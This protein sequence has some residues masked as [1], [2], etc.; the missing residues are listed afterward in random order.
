MVHKAISIFA[1]LL[2]LHCLQTNS[3]I[4]SKNDLHEIS[5]ERILNPV[6]AAVTGIRLLL[7][8]DPSLGPKFLRLAFHDCVGGCDG[9]VDLSNP[10]NKGLD[11]P[12]DAL[13]NIVANH[14]GITPL[15]RADIWALAA[16]TGANWANPNN[17]FFV[18][19]KYYGRTNCENRGTTCLGSLGQ[20]V[21]C[22]AT[23][24][25]HRIM[26]GVNIDTEDVLD[27][28]TD[29]FGFSDQQTVALMGAHTVGVASRSNSG[30]NG[31]AG[32]TTH[33][34]VLDNGYY[35]QIT[36]SSGDLVDN[37]PNWR[38]KLISNTG[39]QD[40]FQWERETNSGPDLIMLN[41]DI[42]LVRTFSN[43]LDRFTGKVFCEFKNDNACNT[44]RTLSQVALYSQ[45]N[46]LWLTDFKSVL[47]KML[48][49]GYTHVNC[50]SP[51]C[52]YQVTG[53]NPLN[54]C[55]RDNRSQNLQIFLKRFIK[56]SFND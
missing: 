45:N 3:T 49:N 17:Q 39:M 12:I 6:T 15:T 31:P 47:Q 9:C 34:N 52:L 28:F 13:S 20:N 2:L 29:N 24:G 51:S 27:F 36:A 22:S 32:W 10:D 35:K 46:D 21:G 25:P 38:Q 8:N 30:F 40:R 42:S 18:E 16:I 43:N 41:S 37:A 56:N 4:L 26:P 48:V 33:N 1:I 5:S 19:F 54:P 14:D 55:Q 7:E 53:Y 50:A 11:T 44:A 23:T